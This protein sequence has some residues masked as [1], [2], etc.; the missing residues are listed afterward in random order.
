MDP[1][2]ARKAR[3]WSDEKI[4]QRL[5]VRVRNVSLREITPRKRTRGTRK[6]EL[7]EYAL[8]RGATI[9]RARHLSTRGYSKERIRHILFGGGGK[10]KKKIDGYIWPIQPKSRRPALWSEWS[11]ETRGRE[12][13]SRVINA[14]SW[15]NNQAKTNMGP[16]EYDAGYGFAVTCLCFYETGDVRKEDL[17]RFMEMYS[18]D[19]FDADRYVEATTSGLKL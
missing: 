7:F 16:V 6:L 3:S 13:P 15:V 9:K 14:I 18:I 1:K 19:P 8:E 17:R 4:Y 2:L 11:S 10:G 12:F 5:G